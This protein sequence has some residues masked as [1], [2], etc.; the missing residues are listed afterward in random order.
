PAG[1]PRVGRR[2]EPVGEPERERTAERLGV[3]RLLDPGDDLLGDAA[4]EPRRAV[5]ARVRVAGEVGR[6]PNE[7]RHAPPA[8]GVAAVRRV[9]GRDPGALDAGEPALDP[10]PARLLREREVNRVPAGDELVE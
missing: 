1:K 9:A 2:G 7:P 6:G 8:V 5:V 3:R 4:A 10:V